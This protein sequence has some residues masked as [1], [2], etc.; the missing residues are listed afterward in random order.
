MIEFLF[1]YWL[2]GGFDEETYYSEEHSGNYKTYSKK[3]WN[4]Y[5][6]M[7]KKQ[8]TKKKSVDKKDK[9]VENK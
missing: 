2:A 7:K 1:G 8:K 4:E 5:Y 6:K 3:E 9:I